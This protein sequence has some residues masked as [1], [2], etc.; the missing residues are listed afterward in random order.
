MVATPRI[1]QACD[2]VL[3]ALVARAWSLPVKAARRLT[4]P[5]TSTQA[6][7]DALHLWIVPAGRESS[8]LDRSRVQEI[9]GV[10]AALVRALGADPAVHERIAADVIAV[11][12]EMMD[13]LRSMRTLSTDPYIAWA[14]DMQPAPYNEQRL[15]QGTLVVGW[16]MNLR[17]VI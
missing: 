17:M 9:V 6:L 12:E 3:G 15:A 11:S 7:G 2:A 10:Q 14:G 8:I 1:I 13:H 5:E 4:W 16:M